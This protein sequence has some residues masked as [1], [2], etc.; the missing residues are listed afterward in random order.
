MMSAVQFV[1]VDGPYSNANA[2]SDWDEFP[3]WVVCVCDENCEPLSKVFYCRS[4][5]SAIELGE[6]MARDRGLELQDDASP[7]A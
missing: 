1:Y 7:W 5:D 3:E 2:Y 4:Y 6:K